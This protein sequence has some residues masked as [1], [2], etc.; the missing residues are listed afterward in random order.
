VVVVVVA[1]AAGRP[2]TR[3]ACRAGSSSCRGNEGSGRSSC[4]PRARCAGCPSD[5]QWSTHHTEAPWPRACPARGHPAGS[6][7]KTAS[8]DCSPAPC[9]VPASTKNPAMQDPCESSALCF[10]GGRLTAVPQ[11]PTVTKLSSPVR[12][13]HPPEASVRVPSEARWKVLFAACEHCSAGTTPITGVWHTPVPTARTR[14]TA[15]TAAIAIRLKIIQWVG[16]HQNHCFHRFSHCS[17]LLDP[18][19]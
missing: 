19:P 2:R 4:R 17:F 15:T 10:L 6:A 7:P 8:P 1:A 3:Q 5:C 13:R 11:G 16:L 9:T 12:R 18:P 14:H